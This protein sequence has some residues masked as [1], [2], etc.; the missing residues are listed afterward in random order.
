MEGKTIRRKLG[1]E[2]RREECQKEGRDEVR[3]IM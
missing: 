2:V 3:K 1:R